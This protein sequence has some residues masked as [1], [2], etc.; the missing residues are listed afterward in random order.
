MARQT[1][2]FLGGFN[3][4]IGN[5]VGYRWKGVWCVR[6]RP[7][8]MHNPRTEKQMEHRGMFKE[9]VRLASRMGQAV[10]LGLRTL[11]DEAD[12]T[13]HNVFVSLNQQAFSLVDGRFTVDYPTLRLS[14]GPAAPVA[15]GEAAVDSGNTLTIS[16]EKNPLRLTAADNY[17]YVYLYAYSHELQMGFLSAPVH[18]REKR[19]AISLPDIFAGKELHL[20]GM[21]QNQQGQMSETIYAGSVARSDSQ[22]AERPEA[23][24]KSVESGKSE[25]SEYSEYSDYSDY[26]DYSENSENSENSAPQ[27]TSPQPAAQQPTLFDIGGL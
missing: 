20:Y 22:S 6:A 13:A 16:F 12:M 23:P 7:G 5:I 14:A 21:T 25:Y 8:H 24:G 17:D 2:G 1:E 19:I 9:E 26:S 27:D 18:R 10:T 11:A 15:F 3:G 4:R